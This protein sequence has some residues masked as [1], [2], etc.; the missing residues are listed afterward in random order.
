MTDHWI[1]IF[2]HDMTKNDKLFTENELSCKEETRFSRLDEFESFRNSDG[3][4]ELKQVW[5]N[6]KTDLYNNQWNILDLKDN[7]NYN[8]WTQSSNP[9]TTQKATVN[10]FN[11]IEINFK[12]TDSH[13][14]TSGIKFEGLARVKDGY[15]SSRA[16]L[17]GNR[18]DYYY[19]IGI[20]I[21]WHNSYTGTGQERS[22]KMS[23]VE[24]YAKVAIM[25][26][27]P[28]YKIEKFNS[29]ML[30]FNQ[31]IINMKNMHIQLLEWVN[32]GIRIETTLNPLSNQIK[33]WGEKMEELLALFQKNLLTLKQQDDK[34]NSSI[35][36]NI[37]DTKDSTYVERWNYLYNIYN[38]L[39]S[40]LGD[41][42]KILTDC[43]NDVEKYNSLGVKLG[44]SIIE[45]ESQIKNISDAIYLSINNLENIIIQTKKESEK[46]KLEDKK[47]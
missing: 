25:K 31:D 12:R 19:A 15:P 33:E 35:T 8:H 23:A 3:L 37:I 45:I 43:K 26:P 14:E 18:G 39:Y 47:M 46:I 24:L 27:F 22:N 9:F 36:V 16:L 13:A 11:P 5:P 17:S 10:D 32:K 1:K 7:K 30:N 6:M 40:S 28:K 20:I 21:D 29:Y 42:I 44:N 2:S 34:I 4:F 38:N 41:D